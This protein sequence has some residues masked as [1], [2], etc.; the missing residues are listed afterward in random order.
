MNVSFWLQVTANILSCG[1]GNGNSNTPVKYFAYK[2]LEENFHM[3]EGS[4]RKLKFYTLCEETQPG[5]FPKLDGFAI[6]FLLANQSRS[7]TVHRI[8]FQVSSEDEFE[9]NN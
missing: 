5:Q 8:F 4:Q 2:E 1:E 3:Q 9:H 7:V 6:N